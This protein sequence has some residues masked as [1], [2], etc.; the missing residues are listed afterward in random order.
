MKKPKLSNFEALRLIVSTQMREYTKQFRREDWSEEL[1]NKIVNR[2]L[3]LIE[4]YSDGM[5]NL[6]EFG[7]SFDI[8][9]NVVHVDL[10]RI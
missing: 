7:I 9:K 6:P 4:K 8:K 1:E 5:K 2:T 10:E 3:R